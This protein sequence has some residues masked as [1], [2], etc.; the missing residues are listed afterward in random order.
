MIHPKSERKAEANP[1]K[2]NLTKQDDHSRTANSQRTPDDVTT[3]KGAGYFYEALI[4]ALKMM[5]EHNFHNEH[6]T[7]EG[8]QHR[9]VPPPAAAAGEV[10]AASGHVHLVIKRCAED[11]IRRRARN[12]LRG[13]SGEPLSAK[14]VISP[15]IPRSAICSWRARTATRP[16][17]RSAAKN[18]AYA[19]I[20]LSQLCQ[21]LAAFSIQQCPTYGV[22]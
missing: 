15:A 5:I 6:P 4:T 11:L 8:V 9:P 12:R 1:L 13:R 16:P 17:T 7:G 20:V 22:S 18:F 3:E 14:R 21:Q 19:A 10:E 2:L